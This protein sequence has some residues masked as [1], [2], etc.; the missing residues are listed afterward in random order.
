MSG[1]LSNPAANASGRSNAPVDDVTFYAAL[2]RVQDVGSSDPA[3]SSVGVDSTETIFVS[4]V[5]SASGAPSA[6]RAELPSGIELV[7]EDSVLSID[8]RDALAEMVDAARSEPDSILTGY[9]YGL[10]GGPFVV[11]SSSP[12]S[13]QDE[14]GAILG[15]F[16]ENTVMFADELQVV[17]LTRLD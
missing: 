12:A 1:V 5:G 8:Q 9:A 15:L 2:G 13:A 11:H 3:F 16:G 10:D 17:N 4:R 6:Y 14:Y 7:F